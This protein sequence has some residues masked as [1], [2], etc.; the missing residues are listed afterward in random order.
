MNDTQPNGLR[1]RCYVAGR[2]P[3]MVFMHGRAA[4]GRMWLRSLWALRRHFRA[5]A[6][7]L[8]DFAR[9][10]LMEEA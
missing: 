10:G 8:A 5:W 4:C 9:R 1:T 2:G 6:I 7:D 3:D